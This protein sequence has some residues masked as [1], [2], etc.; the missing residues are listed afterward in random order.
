MNR[1]NYCWAESCFL[2][3]PRFRVGFGLEPNRPDSISDVPY[4]QSTP[5]YCITFIKS[6]EE[7]LDSNFSTKLLILPGLYIEFGWQKLNWGARATWSSILCLIIVVRVYV[8]RKNAKKNWN[9]GNIKFFVS[10]LPLVVFQLGGTGPPAPLP[11]GN[12]YGCYRYMYLLVISGTYNIALKKNFTGNAKWGKWHN[13]PLNTPLNKPHFLNYQLYCWICF[14]SN[15]AKARLA[16][17][18][19]PYVSNWA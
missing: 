9:W 15:V 8:E 10:F 19:I 2:M 3:R 11:P 12:V 7:G 13:A 5:G 17:F 18:R 1:K 16:C 4:S 6:L 14:V